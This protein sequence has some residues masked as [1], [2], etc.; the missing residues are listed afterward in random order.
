MKDAI[1]S[2]V[3]RCY[4]NPDWKETGIAR[5]A[6]ARWNGAR[7]VTA[8]G[9]LIDMY[10]MGVKDVMEGAF[11]TPEDVEADFVPMLYFDGIP[12]TIPFEEA[13]EI[14]CGAVFYAR[15]LGFPPHPDFDK[16]GRF[17]EIERYAPDGKLRLGGP[18]GKPL[19]IAGP[20][21]PAEKIMRTL[22]A[23]LGKDGFEFIWAPE[24]FVV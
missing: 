13:R 11:R 2:S 4:I 8:T 6:I 12:K 18:N 7:G 21:D 10:C 16:A 17:L 20:F 23:R 1:T 19:Y 24:D 22:E 9:F 14:V 3:F 5:V 15:D